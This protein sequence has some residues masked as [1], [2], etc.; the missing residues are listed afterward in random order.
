M[1]DLIKIGKTKRDSRL[2][3][4][5]LSNTSVPTYYQ[6]AFEIF[7]D[8]MDVLEKKIQA[9]LA[10]FQVSKNREFF[11][12]PLDKAIKLLEKLNAPAEDLD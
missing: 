8:D 9:E 7:S 1:P 3:A 12:Y 5:E 4:K 6:V 11:R 10:D 2:R